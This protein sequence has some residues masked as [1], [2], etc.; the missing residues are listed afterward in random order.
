MDVLHCTKNEVFHY[1]IKDLDLVTFTEEI[2]NG[3]LHFA[4]SVIEMQLNSVSSKSNKILAG[5]KFRGFR[6]FGQNSRNYVPMKLNKIYSPRIPKFNK[7]WDRQHI[8]SLWK[9][10]QIIVGTIHIVKNA[11]SIQT[12]EKDVLYWR[13]L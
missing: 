4:C 6:W 2:V 5:R 10:N 3:K 12:T 13:L 9:L 7:I 1:S 11:F 8:K